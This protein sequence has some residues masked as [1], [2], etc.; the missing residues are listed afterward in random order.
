MRIEMFDIILIHDLIVTLKP[1][2]LSSNFTL[3]FHKR[4]NPDELIFLIFLLFRAPLI[5]A[6]QSARNKGLF[7]APLIFAQNRCVKIKLARKLRE[8][9]Y[10]R[11][12]MG[13]PSLLSANVIIEHSLRCSPFK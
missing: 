3:K 8:L 10:I 1:E 12:L 7:R 2:Y 5:F 6:H 4:Y 11:F 13:P 9:R